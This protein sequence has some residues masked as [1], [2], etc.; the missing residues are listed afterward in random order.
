MV[1]AHSLL[2][3]IYAIIY[4]HDQI[5]RRG[6]H[7][8]FILSLICLFVCTPAAGRCNLHHSV[9]VLGIIFL[10]SK[11]QNYIIQH[12]LGEDSYPGGLNKVRLLAKM[13]NSV[14]YSVGGAMAAVGLL[15]GSAMADSFGGPYTPVERAIKEEVGQFR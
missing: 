9:T 13:V 14:G 10:R 8:L 1:F 11:R 12:T 15:A 6:A 3:G 5:S 7:S 2:R 4:R